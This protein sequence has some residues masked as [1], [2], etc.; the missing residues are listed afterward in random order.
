MVVVGGG[1]GGMQAA[2]T[3]ALRGHSV[4]LFEK[5]GILGGLMNLSEQ[6]VF[7][8]PMAQ[9]KRWLIQKLELA[10]VRVVLNTSADVDT[11]RAVAPDAVIV[12][13]GSDVFIPNIPGFRGRENVVTIRGLKEIKL[14]GT[15]RI[16]TAGGGIVA[17][18]A[19]LGLALEGHDVTVVE[20]L[21]DIATG[22]HKVNRAALK[23]QL[24]MHGV[25]ILTGTRCDQIAGNTL[26][27]TDKDG[28]KLRLPFD[29]ALVALGTR[30]ENSLNTAF[31]DSFPEVYLVGDCVTAG[32]IHVAIHQG[33]IAG[34]RV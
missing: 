11:V 32:R 25:H 4:T 18:E 9:L 15:K 22:L 26:Y 10:G 23:E 28:E 29:Y 17:C 8:Y 16:V 7:K 19:A 1:P 34:S 6:E 24:S 2:I 31:L 27:C 12:A 20:M 3:A 30:P 5:S 21:P 33:Y 14:Q 13:T